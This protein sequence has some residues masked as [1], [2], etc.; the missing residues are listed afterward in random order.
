M[1]VG[2]SFGQC[3]KAVQGFFQDKSFLIENNVSRLSYGVAVSDFN[4]Y[5]NYEFVVATSRE[6][7]EIYL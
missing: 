6:G 4:N 3:A 2:T 1:T 5:G 7:W